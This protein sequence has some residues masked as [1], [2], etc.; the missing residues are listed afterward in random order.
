VSRA[1]G[2]NKTGQNA[3]ETIEKRGEPGAD[4]VAKQGKI[5]Y[6]LFA[7]EEKS[8]QLFFNYMCSLFGLCLNGRKTNKKRQRSFQSR[9]QQL[10]R[11]L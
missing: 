8:N 1:V 2:V 11:W 9:N 4:T 7:E 5:M 6:A 3:I 10:H